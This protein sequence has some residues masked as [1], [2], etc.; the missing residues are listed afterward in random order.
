MK[1]NKKHLYPPIKKHGVLYVVVQR[2]ELLGDLELFCFRKRGKAITCFKQ[3]WHET[4]QKLALVEV[5]PWANVTAPEFAFSPYRTEMWFLEHVAGIFPEKRTYA[6]LTLRQKAEVAT[7][8]NRFFEDSRN[9]ERL[10]K[11]EIK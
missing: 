4:P 1:T 5:R 2:L 6:P 10:L 9:L 8:L 3:L 11:K 7:R